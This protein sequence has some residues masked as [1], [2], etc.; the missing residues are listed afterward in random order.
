MCQLQETNKRSRAKVERNGDH[1]ANHEAFHERIEIREIMA[2]DNS[3]LKPKDCAEQLDT[4]Q[5]AVIRQSVT[6]SHP[7]DS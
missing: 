6:S 4:S 7:C 2:L 5:M 3:R 1:R